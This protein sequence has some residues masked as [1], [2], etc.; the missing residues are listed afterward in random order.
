MES[1][2]ALERFLKSIPLFEY[3]QPPEMMDL[4]RLLRPVVLEEG[5]L[6]FGE[7]DPGKAMWVLG[8]GCEVNVLAT[9]PGGDRPITVATARAGDTVGEMALVD[10]GRRSGTAVVTH[11]G[12]AHEIDAVDFQVLRDSY[13]PAAFKMLRKVAVDLCR[14]IRATTDR[15][16]PSSNLTLDAPPVQFR[17]LPSPELVDQ[18]GPFRK[19]PEVVKLALAQ[20]LT[21]VETDG[22]QPIFG[23]GEHADAAYFVVSGEVT[24]G[25]AGK[26]LA[27]LGPGTMFGLVAAIDQ[28]GRSASCVATGPCRLLRLADADF[29]ALFARGNRFAYHLVDLVARQLVSHLRDTNQLYLQTKQAILPEAEPVQAF[30][31]DSASSLSELKLD[32]DLE[33][34]LSL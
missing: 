24:V 1:N 7:G 20:K 28:G 30:Q 34:E 5:Q 26:T 33:L 22:V 32:L 16:A 23:E 8:E 3:V 12:T 17:P 15:I 10:D 9:P 18:F 25:R 6:L 11:G 4:L 21:L 19:M 14:K 31:M 2:P 13:T 29:D 27:T